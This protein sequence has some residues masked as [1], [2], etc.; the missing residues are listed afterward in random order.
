MG[1]VCIHHRSHHFASQSSH[2]VDRAGWHAK[3]ASIEFWIPWRNAHGP[4][5]G[6]QQFSLNENDTAS[7]KFEGMYKERDHVKCP[8]GHW[9][10]LTRLNYPGSLIAEMGPVRIRHSSH[11]FGW[12]SSH[13][14]DLAG[15][16]AKMASIK[17]WIPWRNAHKPH[18][19]KLQ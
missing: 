19:V 7:K 18:F 13:S 4:H 11:N 12:Q 1:P 5:F 15:W 9:I 6:G 8:R 3:M 17:I 14:V 16:Q 10:F 2:F